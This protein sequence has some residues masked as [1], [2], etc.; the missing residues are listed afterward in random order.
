[1]PFN[2]SGTFVPLSP[3]DFPALPFT[4]ILASQ[5]NNNMND[6]FTSGLT[7]CLTRDGQSPPTANIPMAGFRLINLGSATSDTDAVQ[8]QQTLATRGQVGVVDWNTRITNGIFEATS[9]ALTAPA[10]NFPP[11][12]FLG[13]LIVIAQGALVNQ[14][15]QTA[16]GLFSRQ[17]LSGIWSIWA[18]PETRKNW[19][20]NSAFQ[21]WQ[22][23]TSL[24]ASA[25]GRYLADQF[26]DAATGSTTAPSQ[27]SWP[28]GQTDVDPSA[29]FF[30]R[31]V[32]ASSA[33]AANSASL[34]SIL[35]SVKTL[36][37][38]TCM[39][40]FWAKAATSLSMSTSIEQSFGTGGSPSTNVTVA[41]AKVSLT[42]SWQRFSTP[43]TVPSILG[44][45]LGS[46]NDDFL[47]I[48]FWYD[49]GSNFNTLT[50]SL[51]QQ[52]GQFDIWGIKL[53]EG[54][55]SSSYEVPD[56]TL[57]F[58]RCKRF[59]I[60]LPTSSNYSPLAYVGN[61]TTGV[62]YFAVFSFGLPMRKIPTVTVP[63][64]AV[65]GFAQPSSIL[66]TANGTLVNALATT[67]G[68]GSWVCGLTADARF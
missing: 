45:T 57:E 36:A 23:G 12:T 61:T 68:S 15:Y 28:V 14:L 47:R 53:E 27:Q 39:I 62:S 50:N 31:T 19:I 60:N 65:G 16:N 35:E 58:D 20:V 67:T 40:S 1:M 48:R 46:N 51:G 30:H 4:T 3:P 64:A 10:S 38:R 24:V 56:I 18:I 33:G 34:D 9:A 29:I 49:A 8:L 63:T 13:M 7:N 26:V 37:G 11:T 52:S 21:I 42:T 32:I 22:A 25:S 54:S 41:G 5:F 66:A 43:V 17:K 6:I 44:K 2:G 55:E 59:Y